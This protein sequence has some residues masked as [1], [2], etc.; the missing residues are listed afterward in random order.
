MSTVTPPVHG[1][2]HRSFTQSRTWRVITGVALI[3]GGVL[4]LLMPGIAA[5]A[6]TLVFAWVLLLAGGFELVYAFHTRHEK[7]AT[8]RFI[9]AILTLLLG[10]VILTMPI[11]GVTTLAFI[12]GAFLFLGGAARTALA[13]HMRPARGWGWILVDG[14]LSILLA[15]LIVVG[16]PGTSLALIGFLTGFWLIASGVWRIALRPVAPP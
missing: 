11:V 9:S 2:P 8:W 3:I 12:V 7:G 10:A 6:T 13:F 15:L 16:W 14:I 5:L 4:A 1:G